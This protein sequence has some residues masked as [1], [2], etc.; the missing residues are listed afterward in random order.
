VSAIARLGQV[1]RAYELAADEY[2]AVALRAAE[3][4][5]AHKSARARMI[6]QVKAIGTER[7]SHADAEARAEADDEIA[8]L[9]RDRLI[10]AA[11]QDSHREKLRQLREQ[12]ATGRTAVTSER[13]VDKIHAGGL[14][15]AA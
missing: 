7:I 15:G 10:A 5:A 9:Y 2:R 8:G 3:A 13:E 11:L 1:S 6:L 12:V 4:E 14:S